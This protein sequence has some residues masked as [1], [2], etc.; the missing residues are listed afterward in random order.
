VSVLSFILR[1]LELI[2]QIVQYLP[3]WLL[4]LDRL[5][6]LHDWNRAITNIHEVPFKA[7]VKE[8]ACCVLKLLI[9]VV[10]YK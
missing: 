1:Q 4:G 8:M 2:S 5:K 9:A 6:Y 3:D 10:N 7:A